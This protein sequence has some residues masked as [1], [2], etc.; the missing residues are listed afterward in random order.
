[1]WLWQRF[2]NCGASPP[3]CSVI[4]VGGRVVRL[5][6]FI[7]NET[8]A[9]DKIHSLVDTLL[10]WNINLDLFYNL[11]FTKVYINL[12]KYAIHWL[13]FMSNLFIWIYSGGRGREE[14]VPA[15]KV[16]EPV[17]Y[18][19]FDYR[20]NVSPIHLL[21]LSGVRNFTEVVSVCANRLW[22]GP[23]F[24]KQCDERN[25]SIAVGPLSVAK[26]SESNR[27]L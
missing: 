27:D 10:G 24:E 6:T 3:R 4:H 16:W 23:R 1:M 9:Q 20:N 2:S 5:R 12:E 26:R 25:Y 8:C 19:N 11:N 22:S 21:A 7:L 18:G 17:G 15:I 13:N 14:G